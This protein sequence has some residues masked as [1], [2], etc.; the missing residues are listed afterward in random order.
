MGIYHQVKDLD[1][2]FHNSNY[3]CI[4]VNDLPNRTTQDVEAVNARLILEVGEVFDNVP[5]CTCGALN[6]SIYK[7]VV[8]G[9]CGS[10]VEDVISDTLDSKV[11]IRAPKG[12]PALM[13]FIIWSQLHSYLKCS[14]GRFNLLQWLTDPDY[15][16][17][18]TTHTAIINRILDKLD[19]AGLNVRSYEYFYDNFDEYM[20]FLLTLPDFLGKD[21]TKGETLLRMIRENRDK[22]WCQYIPVPNRAIS[23]I[24]NT[25][26]K[27]W[28]DASTPN[29]LSAVRLMVGI[30]NEENS[31]TGVSKRVRLGRSSRLLSKLTEYYQKDINAKTLGKKPGH[32]RKHVIATRSNFTAR[33]VVTA[34]D[35]PHDYDEVHMPWVFFMNTMAPHVENKLSSKYKLSSREIAKIMT[36]YRQVYHPL[37]HEII[38]ELIAEA[39]HPSNKFGIPVLLNRNPTLKHG[40][41]VLL[42]VTKVKI[43]T[44]DLSASTSGF[45]A[46]WYNGDYDGDQENFLVLLDRRLAIAC[47]PFEAHYSVTNL[48][49]PFK[50]DGNMNLP[51]HTVMSI[52][53]ALMDVS[54]P[55]KEDIDFM[56]GLVA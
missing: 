42:R 45:I 29:L 15:K 10:V 49:D 41:I 38:E 50:L 47:E 54:E 4:V 28:V 21:K 20:E 1:S 5:R 18:I 6:K 44:R 13:N 22:V 3:K 25:N 32:I 51:K 17:S 36:K 40:S 24:E 26:G 55:T 35:G 16:P 7:G 12:V 46:P 14:R 31:R 8:C 23:I 2:V 11:W 43:D 27:R 39:F 48:T 30:D 37:I 53:Q 34:I 52:S 19:D 33:F 9:E 56:A